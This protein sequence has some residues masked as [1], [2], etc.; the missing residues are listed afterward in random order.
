[1]SRLGKRS[2]ASTN[3]GSGHGHEEHLKTSVGALKQS[4]ENSWDEVQQNRNSLVADLKGAGQEQ[5]LK[6]SRGSCGF[7]TFIAGVL[8][9]K[10]QR[11]VAVEER[12]L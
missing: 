6:A 2:T 12:L 3:L 5:Q 4:F 1:M 9:T 10:C 8:P 11:S 7:E